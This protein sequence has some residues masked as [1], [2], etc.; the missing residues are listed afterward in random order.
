MIRV[1]VQELT[2]EL[3]VDEQP[4]RGSTSWYGGHVTVMVAETC[5]AR[6]DFYVSHVQEIV[7]SLRFDVYKKS[8]R[9][10]G[11]AESMVRKLMSEFP[12]YVLRESG[13]PND[14][15][16]SDEL[17]PGGDAFLKGLRA[18]G[19]PYHL[20]RCF[21]QGPESCVCEVGG[22]VRS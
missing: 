19:I 7:E 5:V 8:D 11:H 2:I 18:K 21:R 20:S 12:T 10:Q 13:A 1:E 4:K 14:E 15:P 16:G 9:R 6:L 17:E 3:A 22:R